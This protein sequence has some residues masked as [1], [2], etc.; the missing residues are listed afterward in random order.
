MTH[1]IFIVDDEADVLFTIKQWGKKKG[2][3]VV[4]F[5]NADKLVDN[6]LDQKPELIILDI[7]LKDEDGR[8]ICQDLKNVL[9]FPIKIILFS[10]DPAALLN[11]QHHY[12]DGILN[13]PFEFS[14]LENKLKKHLEK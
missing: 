14:E 13:K 12:A 8:N 1:K 2:Y 10:G 11:Y 7:N 4:T 6:L 5:E 9:P 3:D